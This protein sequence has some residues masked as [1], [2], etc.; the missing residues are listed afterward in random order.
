MN[1]RLGE[2]GLDGP[3]G[4]VGDRPQPGDRSTD[5]LVER[6]GV[7]LDERLGP[8]EVGLG[9]A[10]M[11][12]QIA[13]D[14][15]VDLAPQPVLGPEPR[16]TQPLPAPGDRADHRREQQPPRHENEPRKPRATAA[17]MA[18]LTIAP[19]AALMAAPALP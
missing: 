1:P 19:R 2:T 9:A 18:G 4:I 6:E 5:P 14:R 13:I 8:E 10:G 17:S 7:V 16:F 15:G 11:E 12:P 3:R